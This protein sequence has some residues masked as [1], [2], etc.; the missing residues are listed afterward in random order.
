MS[1]SPT[2][3]VAAIGAPETLPSAENARSV[4]GGDER[5]SECTAPYGPSG[6]STKVLERRPEDRRPL[7]ERLHRW[8]QERSGLRRVRRCGEPIQGEVEVGVFAHRDGALVAHV[9]GVGRCGSPWS[10]AWC[11]PPVREAKATDIDEGASEALARG[12]TVLFVTCTVPHH[13]GDRLDASFSLVRKAHRA[14]RSGRRWQRLR[15]GLGYAGG[16]RAWEVT[17]GRNGWHPH[18]HELVMFDRA[19]S[20]AEVAQVRG[21]YLA[22]YGPVVEGGGRG[23]LHE[24]HGID[25]RRCHSAS[26]LSRYLTKIEGGWGV[27]LELARGDLKRGLGKR[28][29]WEILE[30][31]VDGDEAS[32]ALWWEWEAATDGRRATQ[33]TP[34]LRAKLLGRAREVEAADEQLAEQQPD[35]G[36]VKVW[37]AT[38]R[39][40]VWCH[41]RRRGMLAEL[42]REAERLAGIHLG[43]GG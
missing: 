22:T 24:Q 15:R 11:A 8:Q 29:A 5:P 17:H 25:V 20:D 3:T 35:E 28:T 27:G 40:D 41:A 4:T 23:R 19:L 37:S 1:A 39:G 26:D 2:S 32:Q 31:A 42:L 34:G 38:I 43:R 9:L 18:S 7:R 6:L 36:D 12:W 33:W 10:C 13:W 21:H 30:D 14:T 16:I